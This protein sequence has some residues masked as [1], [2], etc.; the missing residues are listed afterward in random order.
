MARHL[1]RLAIV[2]LVAL[3]AAPSFAAAATLSAHRSVTLSSAAP[4]NAYLAG[5]QVTVT[6]PVAGDL[7]AI[8]GTISSYAPVQD[9]LLAIGGSVYVARPVGGDIRAIGGRV[10]ITSSTTADV[11]AAGGSVSIAGKAGTIIAIGSNVDLSGS[12]TGDVTVY[13][14]DV[15][16]SGTYEG[17]VTVVAS[18]RL[19]LGPNTHIAG[20]LHYKAPQQVSLPAGAQVD[21]GASYT[22]SYAYVP[23]SEEVRRYAVAGAAIF[24]VVRALA[25]V[26]AAGLIAG[27]FPAFAVAV[28][29]RVLLGGPRRT[30]LLGLL[31]FALAVATP[32][33]LVL[34]F[35]SFVGVGVALILGS[36]YSLLVFLSYAFAGIL[37]GAFLRHTLLYRFRGV[38]V[39]TWKDAVL[40]TL[41]VHAIELI[42]KGGFAITCIL[43]ALA[44]GAIAT[45]SY[46]YAFRADY[47]YDF[48]D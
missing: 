12:S 16:L 35:L 1:R 32:I 9:D 34:L 36:L 22:G 45:L 41:V 5:A 40:G 29:D 37:V 27:L 23:T 46:S 4:D 42:P 11:F 14:A 17:D 3:L 43:A 44:A 20:A 19:T 33:L 10:T 2:P 24:F 6:A 26:I 21:G 38:R 47:T 30:V 31:G 39:F 25:G 15:E 13:G 48:D 8:G 7:S 28:S 18:N